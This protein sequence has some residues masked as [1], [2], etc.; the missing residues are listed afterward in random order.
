MSAT[1]IGSTF[2]S[3]YLKRG[4]YK[5]RRSSAAWLSPDVR[6]NACSVLLPELLNHRLQFLTGSR[7]RDDHGLTVK[8]TALEVLPLHGVVD[9]API[10]PEREVTLPSGGLNT[11]TSAVPACAMSAD[12][13]TANS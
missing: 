13:M 2:L 1:G 8:E 12:V 10:A 7:G 4:V 6:G 3:G 9:I 5:S 11:E